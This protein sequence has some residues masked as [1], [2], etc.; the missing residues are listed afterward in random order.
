MARG[1]YTNILGHWGPLSRVH[2]LAAFDRRYEIDTL[3]IGKKARTLGLPP[4]RDE[5]DVI[6]VLLRVCRKRDPAYRKTAEE[7]V[8][9]AHRPKGSRNTKGRN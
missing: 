5:A 3:Y 1:K 8:R 6:E 2:K 7:M 9:R 4:P